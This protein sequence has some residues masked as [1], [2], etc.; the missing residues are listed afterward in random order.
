MGSRMELFAAIRFDWQRHRLS[1]RALADKYGVHRRTVRQAIESVIPPDRRTPTRSTPV[2]D[3]V[4]DQVDAILL[5]DLDAPRKQRHTAR[6]IFERLVDEHDARVSYSY[7][8]KYVHRRRPQIAA[9]RA[10]RAGVVAGFVPQEHLPGAEAEVDFADVW[11]RLVGQM[12]KC[13]L[14]TLRLS[15][16]GKA[17]HRVFATQ[18]QEAFL[19]GHVYAFEILGGVPYGQIRYDNLR[20]AVHRVLFGRN[21]VESARWRAFRAHYG[22]TSF[23]CI[24]GAEGAHEKGGVEGD[25]GRFR[26]THLVPVPE[27][28]SLAELNAALAAADDA[29]DARHIAGRAATVGADFTAEAG[30]LLPLPGEPFD[31][32]LSLSTRVDR[33]ARVTVRQCLYSVPARL[34]G[35]RVRVAL[36]AEQL[37]IFDGSALVATHPRLTT[38]GAS[39]LVLDH[40]L[41]ILAGKPGALPGSTALAQARAAGVFTATH[42]AFWQ[43]ARARH[44]D[45]AGT[46]ALIEVL[47]LHRRLGDQ[48]VLA[49]IRAALDVGSVAPDVVAIEARKAGP[50]TPARPARPAP[51]PRR[52]PAAVVTLQAR[53]QAAA[54]PPDARPAPSVADYD[55]LLAHR[56]AAEGSV[57]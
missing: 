10:G 11:I 35:C 13:F 28:G 36:S 4:R 29:D 30:Y 17:V 3:G 39:H 23:Y 2:L 51:V 50:H 41:E 37:R 31:C 27:V 25:G 18:G 26:R 34:I 5:K 38:R 57:S 55:Q 7:L 20:S 15:C 40:Y 9:Q 19:E 32:A 33:Y 49:G 46:R 54:L 47:L 24:P 56:G 52:S 16:S 48:A 1:I 14:F 42:D 44:G 21:R 22:F 8:A 53:Q 6:R 43:A 12:T 45:A